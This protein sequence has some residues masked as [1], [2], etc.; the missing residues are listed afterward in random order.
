[1]GLLGRTGWRAGVG[2]GLFP[3]GFRREHAER[4]SSGLGGR[5]ACGGSERGQRVGVCMFLF[6]IFFPSLSLCGVDSRYYCPISSLDFY[7]VV[8]PRFFAF[9]CEM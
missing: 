9:F 5:G 4:G 1:M 6:P 3:L 8:G 7:L 2:A